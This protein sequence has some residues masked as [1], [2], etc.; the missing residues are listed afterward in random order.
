[1]AAASTPETAQK[2]APRLCF[3]CD[4]KPRVD[5]DFLCRSCK[6]GY[7]KCYECGQRMRNYPFKLCTECYKQGRG[8][9]RSAVSHTVS[10]SAVTTTA[11]VV[12]AP[13]VAPVVPPTIMS[14]GELYP[15]GGGC[16]GDRICPP[17]YS[18]L[19]AYSYDTGPQKLSEAI[20]IKLGSDQ[21]TFKDIAKHFANEWVKL[22]A[23][24]PKSPIP[25][26]IFAIQ[27]KVL[28]ETFHTYDD[29]VR[30]GKKSSNA[31]LFFHGTTV[32]CDIVT[33]NSWCD[34]PDCGVCGISK[35]GFDALLI[36]KNIPRFQRF[37][38]GIY[39]APNS[40]KCHDYTQGNP[41]YGYRAQ[42]L[43]LV[44]CGAKYE[45]LQDNTKL[46][47]PPDS[48]DSVHG[49]AGGSLNYDEIVVYQ[50]DAVLPQYIVIYE[51][52]GVQKIAK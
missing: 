36:G 9:A 5:G 12:P 47:A 25:K 39:L 32:Y 50:A 29:Q 1:M 37:G 27:N 40:S 6:E 33:T 31:D 38:K 21:N 45:L 11:P 24:C 10:S 35:R 7:R 18:R 15:R 48:F 41:D 42:L 3:Q 16:M 30:S 19:Y 14:D 28:T 13:A 26:A 49:K 52:N 4:E 8:R 20:L 2:L 46:V 43:C 44:A 23:Q 22:T 51:L 34:N 17:P